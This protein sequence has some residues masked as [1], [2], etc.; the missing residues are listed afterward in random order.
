MVAR[1]NQKDRGATKEGQRGEI[2]SIVLDLKEGISA[3]T[4]RSW[5]IWK[6]ASRKRR[7][8]RGEFEKEQIGKDDTIVANLKESIVLASRTSVLVP[9]DF[10]PHFKSK[11][12]FEK[13]NYRGGFARRHL[14]ET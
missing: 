14:G 1:W 7:H 9:K 8:D 6:R 4:T 12:H 13:L 5:W 10:H 2:Q 3:E 11:K